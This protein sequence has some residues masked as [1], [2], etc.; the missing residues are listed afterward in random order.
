MHIER[1]VSELKDDL[2]REISDVNADM[3]HASVNCNFSWLLGII[4]SDNEHV[5][6]L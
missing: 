6:H 1:S 2:L 5:E 3:M 4:A